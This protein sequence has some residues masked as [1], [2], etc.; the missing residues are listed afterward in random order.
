VSVFKQK[1]DRVLAE[2]SA[3]CLAAG[4][5]PDEVKLIAVSKYVGATEIRQ[6]YQAG[7]RDFGESR[8]QA[9]WEKAEALSDLQINWHFIGHLQRN[10]LRRT[11]PLIDL[12]HSGDSLRLLRAVSEFG[13][14]TDREFPVLLEVNV[15]GDA[16]KHGFAAD[17]LRIAIPEIAALPNLKV[18]GL[19]GMSSLAG[20]L[21]QAAI[22]FET[23]Y[24]LRE[25]LRQIAPENLE[26]S[27]LSMGM[28][29]DF[30]AAISH[31]ATMVRIGSALTE[32]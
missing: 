24:L 21:P 17:E 14:E 10:K 23:L 26:L 16:S 7:C 9:L 29:D 25:R 8:P 32:E 13:V 6:L 5:A 12:L 18:K 27:E 2:I 15:S 1:V 3:A 22:D 20:G 4:R 19:M 30:R 31:G 11:L 28:S